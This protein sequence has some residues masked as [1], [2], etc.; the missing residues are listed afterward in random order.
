MTAPDASPP[1]TPDANAW[2]STGATAVSSGQTSAFALKALRGD[3]SG[4]HPKL[5]AAASGAHARPAASGGFAKPA[6]SG[7][8]AK[9][10]TAL[11]DRWAITRDDDF[12]CS[13][14]ARPEAKPTGRRADGSVVGSITGFFKRCTSWLNEPEKKTELPARTRAGLKVVTDPTPVDGTLISLQHAERKPTTSIHRDKSKERAVREQAQ[15]LAAVPE[16]DQ[17]PGSD[18]TRRI[19]AKQRQMADVERL[20]E[21][22]AKAEAA[23]VTILRRRTD[24]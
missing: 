11:S 19:I 3:E 1:P 21:Q 9:P 6:G 5:D 20:R 13:V 2:S 24:A 15:R 14:D 10:A 8:H 22:E 23:Q 17:A 4:A 16:S 12:S 18:L 7:A